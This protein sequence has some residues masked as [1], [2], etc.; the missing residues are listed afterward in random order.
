MSTY[1][2]TH[3]KELARDKRLSWMHRYLYSFIARRCGNKGMMWYT[4]AKMSDEL[5][6]D[7]ATIS[8]ALKTLVDAGWIAK[9]KNEIG[10]YYT[11]CEYPNV[12][13]S[14][15]QT[16]TN[17]QQGVDE[18]SMQALINDQRSLMN[19]QQ[20]VDES[21]TINRKEIERKNKEEKESEKIVGPPAPRVPRPSRNVEYMND[22]LA[23]VRVPEAIT[24][25]LLK[26]ADGYKPF[27]VGFDVV[28]KQLT[29]TDAPTLLTYLAEKSGTYSHQAM[30]AVLSWYIRDRTEGKIKAQPLAPKASRTH[31]PLTPSN[32]W[33]T[34]QQ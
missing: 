24:E 33:G 30:N 17:R 26:F 1:A 18:S 7:K 4:V 20:N 13:E 22:R 15:T 11:L 10:S 14:S 2:E 3:P 31:T 8:R 5:E 16:L 9:H 28:L 27:A 32:T 21:S 34:P 19:R 6:T 25:V 23:E 29:E 12:D